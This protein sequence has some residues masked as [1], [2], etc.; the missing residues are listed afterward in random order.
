MDEGSD[1]IKRAFSGVLN[2]LEGL[3]QRALQ[4][5]CALRTLDLSISLDLILC[6]YAPFQ[7]LVRRERCRRV[8]ASTGTIQKIEAH[9]S[10]IEYYCHVLP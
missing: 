1:V 8:C 3:W 9:A 7:V 6:D 4:G 5:L 10:S 2:H